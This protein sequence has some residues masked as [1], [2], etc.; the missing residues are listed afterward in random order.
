MVIRKYFCKYFRDDWSKNVTVGSFLN[1]L[2]VYAFIIFIV[3]VTA[4]FAI[5]TILVIFGIVTGEI[6]STIVGFW[7]AIIF[8]LFVFGL[9]E[10]INRCHKRLP[11]ISD[12]IIMKCN[13]DK[14][15]K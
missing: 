4:L 8:I 7:T 10:L 13:R 3:T 2:S 5:C 11:N 14:G 1:N 9:A 12:R 15:D 6:V